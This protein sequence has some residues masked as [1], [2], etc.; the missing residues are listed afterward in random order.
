MEKKEKKN[1]PTKEDY[2]F[3]K[4][5]GSF[6]LHQQMLKGKYPSDTFKEG[7]YGICWRANRLYESY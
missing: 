2:K 1:K 6:L 3:Y 7:T 4:K 5:R